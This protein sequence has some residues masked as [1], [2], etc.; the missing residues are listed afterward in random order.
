MENPITYDGI[1][2]WIRLYFDQHVLA[3]SVTLDFRGLKK[4]DAS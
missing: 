3:T 1:Y 2:I 4:M